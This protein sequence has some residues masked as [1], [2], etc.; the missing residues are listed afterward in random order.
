M[1]VAQLKEDKEWSFSN[2]SRKETSYATHGY[3]KYPAKFIPQ[4]VRKIIL[5]YSNTG[6][7]ILDCFGGC[8]T[9]LVES[10]LNQRN[11]IILDVN[12]VAILIAKAKK[13]AI[14]PKILDRYNRRVL[15]K[16]D[17]L[18]IRKDYY[19]EVHPRLKY[20]FKKS[21]YNKLMEIYLILDR[22]KNS[23]I[24]IFYRCC[25]SNILKNC[26]IWY[27]KS[28][29]PMRDLEKMDYDPI[30]SF[31]KHLNFMTKRN[32]EYYSLLK[33]LCIQKVSSKI[34]ERDARK[35]SLGS[36][37]IDLIITSPPYAM[38]YEYA[39]IHQLT[40]LWFGFTKDMKETKKRFIGTSSNDS[41]L[42]FD[43]S[44]LAYKIIKDLS[45]KDKTLSNQVNKYYSDLNLA[46]REMYRVLKKNGR[47]CIIIG[48][49]QYKNVKVKNMQVSME[50]LKNVGFGIE[51]V[52]KR[53]LSSKTFTPYRNSSGKFTNRSKGERRIYQY[54]YLI[55]SRK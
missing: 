40:L 49:T 31:V 29:K 38:S 33:D 22:I 5:E 8:G 39:D 47:A 4:I 18:K 17:K 7:T 12:K 19:S 23:G 21:Q 54:E 14:N 27:S 53:K 42:V 1:G 13:N 3:H 9:T 45:K 41:Q 6:E 46:Y 55:I 10:K 43:E 28:I 20:W 50:I 34:L 44:V 26:S 35:T 36:N 48:N 32:E 51:K 25:F 11:S 30:E 16:F 24:K 52:I 37:S 15:N 2:L